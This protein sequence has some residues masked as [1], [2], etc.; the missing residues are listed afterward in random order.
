M[1]IM[2]RTAEQSVYIAPNITVRVLSIKK[3]QVKLGFSAPPETII[4]PGESI[5][6]VKDSVSKILRL[7]LTG[8]LKPPKQAK[9]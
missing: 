8:E 4:K 2:T 5:D 1:L 7:A 3:G 6:A 9:K